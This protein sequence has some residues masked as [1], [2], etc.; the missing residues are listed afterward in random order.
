MGVGDHARARPPAAVSA[1]GALQHQRDPH[2]DEAVDRQAGDPIRQERGAALHPTDDDRRPNGKES[3]RFWQRGGGYDHNLWSKDKVWE[4]I[5]Y[6]HTNPV[7]RGLVT[8]PED[9]PWSSY[10]DYAGLRQ[11][12]LP[13]DREFLPV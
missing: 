4:K 6:I 1:R 12:A 7:Q 8:R 2:D 5:D 10:G 11:G 3:L 9:W 13:I